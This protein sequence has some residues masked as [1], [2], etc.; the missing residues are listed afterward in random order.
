MCIQA[1]GLGLPYSP[2]T[3]Q[4]TSTLQN[5]KQKRRQ[6]TRRQQTSGRR[7]K[8]G[9]EGL[10]TTPPWIKTLVSEID[11]CVL[12]VSG[13]GSDYE[14]SLK[15]DSTNVLCMLNVCHMWLVLHTSNVLHNGM[16]CTCWICAGAHSICAT[17]S[18]KQ[19]IRSSKTF[20]MCNTLIERN[21]P[22]GGVS[23][24]LLS[25]IKNRV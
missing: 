5:K 15:Q 20:D 10:L 17:Y 8:K 12:P 9:G 1:V 4:H 19:H 22:L 23:Y 13:F 3:L 24:L 7:M 11:I 18:T 2:N 6:S 14:T 21:P 25:L 16:C